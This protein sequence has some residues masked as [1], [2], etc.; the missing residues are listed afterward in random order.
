MHANLSNTEFALILLW[1]V[2]IQHISAFSINN[3]FIN[4]PMLTHKSTLRIFNTP[5]KSDNLLID[6]STL[7]PSERERLQWIKK[8]STEADEI[9]KAAGFKLDEPDESIKEV[10]DTN[11]SGQST[12]ETTYVT[13]NNWGD[14]KIR[15]PL[16]IGDI[17]ALITFAA[18][19]RS[20]HA[21]DLNLIDTILTASPF[22]ISWL[23]LSPLLGAYSQNA[24][25]SKLGAFTGLLPG[26]TLSIPLGLGLRGLM[27]GAMPPTPFIVVSMTAT[28]VLLSV[29]RLL[30]VTLFGETSD[31]EYRK[32]GVFE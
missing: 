6:E 4:N 16:M 1:N 22:L 12:V 29:W 2:L 27:K 31:K 24:T 20:N 15:W 7:S 14:L 9:V 8:L 28:L 32:A 19:G 5:E 25:A 11:W 3:R 10:S 23:F 13:G 18:V 17:I 21:E 30:Y 26:W